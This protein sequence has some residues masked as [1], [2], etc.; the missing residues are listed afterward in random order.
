MKG[1][2][3]MDKLFSAERVNAQTIQL[4]SGQRI[5][6]F[7][8]AIQCEPRNCPVHRPS[9]HEYRDLPLFFTGTYMVRLTGEIDGES[10]TGQIIDP[11]DY[12]YNRSGKAIL[13]NSAKCHG[14]NEEIVSAFRHD[15]VTCSCGNVSVDGGGSYLRRTTRGSADFK[16]TSVVAT[17][18]EADEKIA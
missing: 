9:E 11:D 14:C 4:T 12:E 15:F 6:A 8:K 2:K 17:K 13:R 16:D 18:P 7:H 5:S 10:P 3:K 1:F